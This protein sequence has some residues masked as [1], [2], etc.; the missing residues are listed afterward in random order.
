M[1]PC[2]ET[3]AHSISHHSQPFWLVDIYSPVPTRKWLLVTE[4]V[5]RIEP[6]RGAAAVLNR[7]LLHRYRRP[8]TP[9]KRTLS[10]QAQKDQVQVNSAS[11]A[12]RRQPDI[13][14]NA[15]A[16]TLACQ[17]NIISNWEYLSIKY[18]TRRINS[19]NMWGLIRSWES[20]IVVLR[21]RMGSKIPGLTKKTRSIVQLE[22][23]AY[24]RPIVK[25]LPLIYRSPNKIY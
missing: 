17:I 14:Y 6:V 25:R 16:D 7:H 3:A 1:H 22:N 15:R 4:N 8:P 11:I 2:W 19:M 18:P 23:I 12:P 20:W 5:V 24:F 13:A 21:A 9:I 10:V